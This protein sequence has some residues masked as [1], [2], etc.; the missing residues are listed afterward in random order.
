MQFLLSLQARETGDTATAPTY[1]MDL[2]LDGDECETTIVASLHS[3]VVKHLTAKI[4]AFEKKMIA[5]KRQAWTAG[6]KP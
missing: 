6:P 3:A 2:M 1:T 5:S 4:E